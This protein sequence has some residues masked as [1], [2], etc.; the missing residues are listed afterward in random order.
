MTTL[1]LL[2]LGVTAYLTWVKL[3]GTA[4]V[5]AIVSGCETVEKSRYS[6]FLGI[7][8]AAFGLMGAGAMVLGSLWWWRRHDRRGLW[9]AYLVGLVS[10]PILGWL[11]Y[12]ELFV[13]HAV[14]L[15]CVTYA[16]LV[17]AVW[18]V[19]IVGIRA[20]HQGGRA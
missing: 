18:V 4:P 17:I 12:L 10:L 5:C 14:C 16:V 2:A 13:I 6:E 19:S 1:S 20:P 11:T 9:L 15:W 3:S 8:V 7:P